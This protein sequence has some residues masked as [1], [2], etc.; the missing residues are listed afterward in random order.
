MGPRVVRTQRDASRRSLSHV[1]KESVVRR[2]SNTLILADWTNKLAGPLKIDQ[3]QN[4]AGIG[5]AGRGA[6]GVGRCGERISLRKTAARRVRVSLEVDRRVQWRGH[7]HMDDMVAQI[8]GGYEPVLRHLVLNGKV[9]AL[10]LRRIQI[11]G[12]GRES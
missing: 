9:P 5:V 12:H 2:I 7:K 3:R 10:C 11:V 4:A 8:A 6:G 1:Q